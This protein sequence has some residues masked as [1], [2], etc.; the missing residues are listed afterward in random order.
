MPRFIALQSLSR[1]NFSCLFGW[2]FIIRLPLHGGAALGPDFSLSPS[3][4]YPGAKNSAG[5]QETLHKDMS[6]E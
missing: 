6:S 3:H 2:L 5:P 4:L 1:F